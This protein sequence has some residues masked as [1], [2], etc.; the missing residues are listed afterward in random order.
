MTG[1]TIIL[2]KIPVNARLAGHSVQISHVCMT[3]IR[4]EHFQL[5]RMFTTMFFG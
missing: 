5:T 3:V 1:N 2:L 4:D